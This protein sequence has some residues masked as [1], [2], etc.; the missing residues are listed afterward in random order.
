MFSQFKAIVLCPI[1]LCRCLKS[2]TISFVSPIYVPEGCSEVSTELPLL[3]TEQPQ[4]SHSAITE[5]LQTSEHLHGPPLSRLVPTVWKTPESCCLAFPRALPLLVR[6]LSRFPRFSCSRPGCCGG[7][8]FH[9]PVTGVCQ[10][11]FRGGRKQPAR[12]WMCGAHPTCCHC[13]EDKA[14]RTAQGQ[15]GQ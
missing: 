12:S 15:W 11:C 7:T 4:L 3:W 2:F 1:T 13:I 14:Y 6:V 8:S 9:F 5:V 10:L